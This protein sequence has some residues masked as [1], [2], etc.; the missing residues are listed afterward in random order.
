MSRIPINIIYYSIICQK[1][2]DCK[3]KVMMIEAREAMKAR[4]ARLS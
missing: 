4:E 2:Q 3:M 1:M